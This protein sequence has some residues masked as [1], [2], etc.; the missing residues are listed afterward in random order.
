MPLD[1]NSGALAEGLACY[2]S[3]Q[4]F[5]AHEHWESVWTGWSGPEKSL[6]QALIQLAVAMHHLR[7]G[8][9]AGAASLLQRALRRLEDYP[10]ISGGVAVGA[11]RGDIAAWLTAIRDNTECAGR[12]TPRILLV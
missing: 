12:D 2:R 6:L 3:A 1:W 7:R 8:N 9:R 5:D 10:A 4:F 11:L